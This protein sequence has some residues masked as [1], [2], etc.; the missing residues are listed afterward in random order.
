MDVARLIA[1]ANDIAAFFDG[2]SPES[3]P[4]S[5][6]SHLVKFWEPRMRREIAAH[7]AAGGAGLVPSAEE[8]VR[9][10]KPL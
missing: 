8:A 10:L 5:V 9:R 2:E 4:E 7:V 6:R 1:M 3:A